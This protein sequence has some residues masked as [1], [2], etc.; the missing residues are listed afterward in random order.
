MDRISSSVRRRSSAL[1]AVCFFVVMTSLTF[2]TTED[3]ILSANAA[4]AGDCTPEFATAPEAGAG[5]AEAAA[6]GVVFAA[7][8]AGCA[9][10]AA[11]LAVALAGFV[12]L[13]GA[14]LV[15]LALA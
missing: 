7:E 8:A 2:D 3:F 6:A 1:A 5:A 11:A 15:A 12:A 10:G 14:A 9:A 13:A 4:T